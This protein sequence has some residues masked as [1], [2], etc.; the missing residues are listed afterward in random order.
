MSVSPDL[1]PLMQFFEKKSDRFPNE[2]SEQSETGAFRHERD[3]CPVI[4]FPN[5]NVLP[6][7][8]T[9]NALA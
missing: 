9:G 7:V 8:R 2:L 4:A 3:R 1:V 5:R 6:V